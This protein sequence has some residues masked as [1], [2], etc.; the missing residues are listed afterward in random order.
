MQL[1]ACLIC[2]NVSLFVMGMIIFEESDL[3]HMTETRM[4]EV[5]TK[6][7]ED[8]CID[9]ILFEE[10]AIKSLQIA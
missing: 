4:P 10:N 2:K 6:S 1:H 9:V 3:E 7:R 8:H 5:V